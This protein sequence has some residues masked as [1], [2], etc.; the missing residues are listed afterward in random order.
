MDFLSI[1]FG[2]VL[3]FIL[4]VAKD[5]TNVIFKKEYEL[6]IEKRLKSKSIRTDIAESIAFFCTYW[7]DHQS[8]DM[9]LG[10][11]RENIVN[12]INEIQEKYRVGAKYL[13]RKF[14]S[15][16][17]EV[18]N[19]FLAIAAQSPEFEDGEWFSQIKEEGDQLCREFYNILQ[20]EL[21]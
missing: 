4:P 9:E 20:E 3:G 2:I 17:R 6:W 16:I 11:F 1:L 19:N 5:A 13:D 7:E 15:H 8:T 21:L 18:C 10:D 12:Q 14:I